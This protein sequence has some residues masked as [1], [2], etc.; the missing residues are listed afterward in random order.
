MPF[1]TN[2]HPTITL[3]KTQVESLLE[4]RGLE[5]T[6]IFRN[7]SFAKTDREFYT[8]V[9]HVWKR[10]DRLFKLARTYY[11]NEDV[12]WMIGLFNRKPTDAHYKFG[13]IVLIPMEID[14]FFN[15]VVK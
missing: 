2:R 3:S 14:I 9:E 12:F 6:T 1:Y 10:G 7:F 4:K 13:D 5:H 8:F 15:E 11:D